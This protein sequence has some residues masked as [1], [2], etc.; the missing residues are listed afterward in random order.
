MGFVHTHVHSEYSL[1]DGMSKIKDIV[2]K[3]K[4]AGM[5]AC[6]L[7]DHG[8]AYGLVEFYDECKKNGIKPI[9][10]CEVYEAPGSR[11]EKTGSISD[12]RYFH[13]I[14]LVKN[15][16]G[17]ENLCH[18]IS[19]SNTE[20]FYY[21][22]RI[23]FE[24]LEQFH[25]GLICQSA[26][27]AGRIPQDILRGDLEAAREDIK[28]YKDLF[29][30]DFYL[31]IMNHGMEEER[32]VAYTLKN[33]GKEMGVKLVCSNDSHY[34]NPE[35]SEA[36]EW[37]LCLQTQ[38]TITDEDRLVYKGDYSLKTE[39][40][41]RSLFPDIP[42][43]FDNTVEIAEKCSFDFVYNQYKM[44]AVTIPEEYG[45]NYFKYLS[46]ETWKGFEKRYP[47]NSCHREEAKERIR[48]EL[49]V[50]EQ[51][52]FAEYFLDTRKTVMWAKNNGILVGPGRGSAA[53]SVM[54]YCLG[55]TDIEPIEYGL[56]FERF[57][58]PERVSMP[59]IDVDYEYSR[60]D[61][62]IRFEAQ[63][64]GYDHFSKIITFQTLAAK[65]VLRDLVRVAGLPVQVGDKLA[66]MIPNDPKITLQSAWDINPELKETIGS[67][68]EL[69]K[70]WEIARK[71]EGTSKAA[72]T[73]ACGH[74]PT[75]VPC[76]DRFPVSVDQETG[77]L[78]CQYNMT[79]VE[80]LGNLKKDLLMLRNLTIISI[81]QEAIRKN[82]G[83][84]VPLWNDKILNDKNA[85]QLFSSG[86]TNGVFQ[87]ES[88]GMTSFM[89]QLQPS[90]F[91][92]IIAGVALYRP[93]P[94]DF[95]PDYIRG[96][97]DPSSVKYLTPLLE[98]ILKATYG[99]IVYQEQV[100]QIV[101]KLAGFSMGRADLLRKA[102][103]KKK[104]DIMDEEETNFVY[105]SEE[106]GIPGCISNGIPEDIAHEIYGQMKSFAQY[107]FNK[108][109]AAAYAAIAMQ[110]AYLKANYPLEFAAGLLT[111]VM[112]KT[113]KLVLYKAD[114][115]KRGLKI[116]KPD[117]NTSGTTFT[118]SNE[119]LLYGLASIK[120]AGEEDVQA[121]ID[122][123]EK[124]GPY[125]SFSEFL[126][127]N[128]KLSSRVVEALIKAGAMDSISIKDGITRRAMIVSYKAVLDSYRKEEKEQIPGQMSLFDLPMFQGEGEEMSGLIPI[129]KFP[130]Y[131]NR[132]IYKMEKEATG[133][134]ISGHPLDEYKEHM[135]EHGC[136][137]LL[138][139]Q[140][141]SPLL[142]GADKYLVIAGMVTQKKVV[143]TK[144]D[145]KPMAFVT[146]S[147]RDASVDVTVFPDKYESM[148]YLFSEDSPIM[149]NIQIKHSQEH[150]TSIILSDAMDLSEKG[151]NIWIRFD[152]AQNYA[153]S[154][155]TL[156]AILD[157]G[158]GGINDIVIYQGDTKK[159]N[160]RHNFHVTEQMKTQLCDMFGAG[161][162]AERFDPY[163]LLT[164]IGKT[165]R[166]EVQK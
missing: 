153:G 23:D 68:P 88:D 110:T 165:I 136:V 48:Y 51:M 9:L 161:N 118:V 85:L 33:L 115:D 144:R 156:D 160:I 134:Y 147:D 162:V 39:E 59:D 114:Y 152:T 21:K 46:D 102:M 137:S 8:V 89:R 71:L 107:A 44:P 157:R 164:K 146:I 36:H 92:D 145:K 18:L 70:I 20:G 133:F 90:C 49:S 50:V 57:L 143:F 65:G 79:Q 120:G 4:D 122:E 101:Q 54:V 104:Q 100:M 138:D 14:L 93:G 166:K 34:V 2:K 128:Y 83:V 150:G 66:R 151:M 111:S 113:D 47:E 116:Q 15:Q 142:E 86:N 99:V 125:K 29:G 67:D 16:T 73:H 25:E 37:L 98:P 42:E 10:G 130:E 148:G 117:I 19:R 149:A 11:F 5:S 127:R 140:E 84:D 124:N 69:R 1:L 63:S 132:E 43:A 155:K 72:S 163:P 108:S 38:K 103:G 97:H 126:K 27:L 141:E 56:L 55:I 53:G 22:P 35:D 135:Q 96:K 159:I 119:S 61:D 158:K 80:H 76:E 32:R 74:V 95:I 112:D 109:H 87:F 58:N 13:L 41:M 6:A 17:Y 7:T 81:A 26:C 77:Y 24:L 3:V 139:L 123:R 45:A 131:D 31:E 40:E 52:N 82:H 106:L 12:D 62:V 121:I 75:A 154:L 91:E 129:A 28:R 105:G 60:K 30:D 78:V 64:N 94:M